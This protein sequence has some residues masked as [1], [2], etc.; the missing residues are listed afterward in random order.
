[1]P[2]YDYICSNC[3][4]FS[5]FRPISEYELP[6]TCP[7][8]AAQAPR[9]SLSVPTIATRAATKTGRDSGFGRYSVTARH[10]SGCR[11]CAGVKIPR[12]EWTSKLL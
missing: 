9:A 7:G 1:M 10:G 8:C 5:D 11:C 12:A 6:A 3:G 4:S 2:R